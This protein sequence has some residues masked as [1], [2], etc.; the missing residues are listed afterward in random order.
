VI[1]RLSN[2]AAA[3]E[4]KVTEILLMVLYTCICLGMRVLDVS[5]LPSVQDTGIPL[6]SN[7]EHAYD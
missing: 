2:A 5:W 6:Y 4:R 7:F 3:M 1:K